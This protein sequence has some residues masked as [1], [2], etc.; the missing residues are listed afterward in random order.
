MHAR[1]LSKPAFLLSKHRYKGFGDVSG[2]FPTLAWQHAHY[3]AEWRCKVWQSTKTNME[4]V[5][6]AAAFGRM[7]RRPSTKH[8]RGYGPNYMQ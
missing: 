8:G 7:L 2:L 4:N 6:L 5:P 3:G 1:A